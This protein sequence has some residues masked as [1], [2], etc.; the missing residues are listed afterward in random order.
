MGGG[1]GEDRA[2]IGLGEHVGHGVLDQHAVEGPPQAQVPHVSLDVLGLGVEGPGEVQH[3]LGE[4][5]E[6]ALAVPQPV[7][8]VARTAAEL[9]QAAAFRQALPEPG[10]LHLVV[11]QGGE[12]G[13][14]VHELSVHAHG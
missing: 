7:G 10:G 5:G 3:G 14:E 1:G 11:L 6:H 2:Q 4:V 9:E 13:V 8:E 12:Q